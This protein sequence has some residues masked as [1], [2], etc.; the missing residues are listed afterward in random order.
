MTR[1]AQVRAELDIGAECPERDRDLR[2][3]LLM[4]VA[5]SLSRS[6]AVIVEGEG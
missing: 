1:D 4:C 5:A 6:G 2:D 3:A